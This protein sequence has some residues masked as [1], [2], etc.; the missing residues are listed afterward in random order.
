MSTTF[1]TYGNILYH[2]AI[3]L[4]LIRYI[5]TGIAT[6]NGIERQNETLKHKFLEGYKDST[7]S[8]KLESV[9]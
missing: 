2:L 3:A 7:L 4:E 6:N 8:E 1:K 5:K 9:Q